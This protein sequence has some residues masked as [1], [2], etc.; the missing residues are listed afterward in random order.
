MSIDTLNDEQRRFLSGVR[1]AVVST[2]RRDG[3]PHQ[4]VMWYDL[5]PEHLLLNTP[6][7]SLKVS[8]LR[9]DPRISVCVEDGCEYVTLSGT[10]RLSDDQERSR[11]EYDELGRRYRLTFLQM[12]PRFVLG[13]LRGGGGGEAPSRERVS[14]YV[15]EEK[16]LGNRLG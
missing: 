13:M 16:V 3:T 6:A 11:A 5:R 9:S 15:D 10:A 14:I 8:H 2:L 1:F 12:L 4:T 7:A